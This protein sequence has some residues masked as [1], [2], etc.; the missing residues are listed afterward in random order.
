MKNKS[1]LAVG[2][3]AEYNPFHDGHAYHI[4]KAKE[5]SQADYC[6]VAMSGDF[7]QRGAPAFYDKYTRTA[8]ALSCGAD[9]VIELPSVFAS[10]SAEDFA[11]SGIALLNNLGVVG[12]V[13]FGSECGN[14]EKTYRYCFY[15]SHRTPCLYERAAQRVEKG[16]HLSPGQKS[17]PYFLWDLKRG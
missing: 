4:R 10:S 6:I 13:C 8:M 3:I 15:F 1:S 5:I 11:A 17:G 16:G 7:V 12:S 14:V 9:L 2:I